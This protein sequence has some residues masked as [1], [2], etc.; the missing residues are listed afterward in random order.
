MK[1]VALVYYQESTF[2]DMTE[3]AWHDLNGGR[4]LPGRAGTA[5]G[6]VRDNVAGP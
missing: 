1:Y 4:P 2:N 6:G 3:Q 5:A